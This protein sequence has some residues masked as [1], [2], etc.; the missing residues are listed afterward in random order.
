MTKEETKRTW[1]VWLPQRKTMYSLARRFPRI[2]AH[3]YR[4]RFLSGK[5]GQID[6]WMSVSLSRKVSCFIYLLDP[7]LR[8][9]SISS[10]TYG[11][12]SGAYYIVGKAVVYYLHNH[13]VIIAISVFIKRCF[14]QVI[15]NTYYD[16]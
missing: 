7:N 5:H 10:V 3:L 9:L 1:D 16:S 15:H 4:K 11:S 6:E 13:V 14:S 12:V 2:L 8:Q